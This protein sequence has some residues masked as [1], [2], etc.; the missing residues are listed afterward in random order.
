MKRFFIFLILIF[1]SFAEKELIAFQSTPSEADPFSVWYNEGPVLV[2]AGSTTSFEVLFQIPDNGYLYKDQVKLVISDANGIQVGNVEMPEGDLKYDPIFGKKLRVYH[3]EAKLSVSLTFPSSLLS[4]EKVITGEIQYQ[5]CS[6]KLCY[7]LTHLPFKASFILSGVIAS[8]PKVDRNDGGLLKRLK[9]F[10]EVEDF[11]RLIAQHGLWLALLISFLGGV[12]T[13][14]TPCVWPLIPVT[15]ALI[16]VRKKQSAK[17][18]LKAT[19]IMVLGMAVMYSSLGIVAALVGKGL[20]FLFQSLFFLIT[21]DLVLFI[22]AASLLGLFHIQLPPKYQSYIHNVAAQGFFGIFF[23]GLTLGLMAAPCVGPVVG[24]LLFYVAKNRDVF[25]GFILLLAYAL[26]MG[27]LFMLLGVFYGALRS[28]IKSGPWLL[29]FKRALGFVMLFLALAYAATLYAEFFGGGA[30]PNDVWQHSL[31]EGMTQAEQTHKPMLIDFFAQWCAPCLELEKNVWSQ[32][33]IQKELLEKWVP[34][35]IDC[36]QETPE[37]KEAVDRFQVI[38]WPTIV[39]LDAQQTEIQN[40]RLVGKVLSKEEM[41][42]ILE[43]VE[44]R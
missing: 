36:T 33:E 19:F 44:S 16:G 1:F 41:E 7:K 38:G 22:M 8:P 9:N 11:R 14:F 29:W 15:L 3:H 20:G 18:N 34:V 24:P 43:R 27:S 35:K 31:K 23:I 28:R 37:C 39:F 2:T 30:K 40:E 25:L 12:A 5:G 21:F 13:D 10:I 26:G 32:P 17:A 6:D 42:K 4:G